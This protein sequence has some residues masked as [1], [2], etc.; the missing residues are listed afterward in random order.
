M[1]V[2]RIVM[3]GM[4]RRKS[5]MIS[6]YRAPFDGRR[7]ARSTGTLT[8]CSGIS[9]YAQTF[10]SDA[11]ASIK[12][13]STVAGYRYSSRIHAMPSTSCKRRSSSASPPRR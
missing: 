5:S 11:I 1:N 2:E 8:C 6:R 9:M 12:S 3:P 7:I 4:R 13:E 10:G